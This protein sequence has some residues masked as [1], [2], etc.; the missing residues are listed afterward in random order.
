M[1]LEQFGGPNGLAAA[2]Q[3]S[4][5]GV[6]Y[7]N[8]DRGSRDGHRNGS[9]QSS[10]KSRNIGPD[11]SETYKFDRQAAEVEPSRSHCPRRGVNLFNSQ[12]NLGRLT[13][14]KI[15]G[16]LDG[17]P[18]QQHFSGSARKDRYV[19]CSNTPSFPRQL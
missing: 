8:P 4:I 17:R 3:Y 14:S 6:N 19:A 5:R 11:A 1:L 18:A 7:E 16:E 12:G 2:L 10:G 9:T 13:T 15:T